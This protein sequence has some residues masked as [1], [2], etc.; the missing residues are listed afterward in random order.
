[1]ISVAAGQK[2]V[3]AV[4]TSV[5]YVTF[6]KAEAPAAMARTAAAVNFILTSGNRDKFLGRRE[7]GILLAR[8]SVV[9]VGLWWCCITNEIDTNVRVG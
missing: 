8:I 1:M 2:V 3:T 7:I 5:V 6:S 4:T 9:V